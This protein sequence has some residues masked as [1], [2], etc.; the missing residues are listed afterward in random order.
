L[1]AVLPQRAQAPYPT[2]AEGFHL[3]NT[4]FIPS[5]IS[6]WLTIAEAGMGKLAERRSV[7]TNVTHW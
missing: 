1:A 7:M 6:K 3:T 4:P 2:V 5:A